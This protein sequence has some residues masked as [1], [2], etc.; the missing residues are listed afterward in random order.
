MRSS[1]MLKYFYGAS[2]TVGGC[3]S[4]SKILYYCKSNGKRG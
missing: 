2:I 1:F 4:G 3:P